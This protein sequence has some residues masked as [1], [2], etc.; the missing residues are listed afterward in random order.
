MS[1]ST[2]FDISPQYPIQDYGMYGIGNDF[3]G[4]NPYAGLS[5]TS[6]LSPLKQDT[7]SMGNYYKGDPVGKHKDINW[8]HV[9]Y[10]GVALIGGIFAL[11]YG[12]SKML[13]KVKNLFKIK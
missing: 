4:Y 6:Y 1:L 5:N 3:G 13:G 2:V 10:G 8:E 7:F 11:K 9:M 12:A